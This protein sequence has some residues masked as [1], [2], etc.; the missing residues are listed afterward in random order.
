MDGQMVFI[1][2]SLIFAVAGYVGAIVWAVY[3]PVKGS[4]KLDKAIHDLIEMEAPR[5]YGRVQPVSRGETMTTWHGTAD[6][7]PG[8]TW[9]VGVPQ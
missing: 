2:A 9:Y 5:R 1:I 7:S 6:P 3:A 8:R 4:D